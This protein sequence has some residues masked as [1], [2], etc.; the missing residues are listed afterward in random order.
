MP[1]SCVCSHADS[2]PLFGESV[3][4][5]YFWQL[6]RPG[7]ETRGR[8]RYFEGLSISGAAPGPI[9]ATQVP[10]WVVTGPIFLAGSHPVPLSGSHPDPGSHFC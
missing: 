6:D 9:F 2:S 7:F 3:V 1:V 8:I 10:I 5:S 4:S